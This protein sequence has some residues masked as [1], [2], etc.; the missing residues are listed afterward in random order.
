MGISGLP[1]RW[2]ATLATTVSLLGCSPS[3]E[4]N[5][6]GKTLKIAFFRDNTTLVSLDPFQVYWLEHRV[7]LRNVAES[8]TDQD[9]Q[10][11]KII[12]WLATGWDISDNALEYT[13]HLRKDVT[14]SNG[15][16]F[17]ARAVKTA[18]DADKAFAAQLPATF[19]ATYLAGY[20]HAEVVDDFT[21]KL[22]LTRPNAGF[23]Q[24]TSTT[25]LAILA[26]ESYAKS[27]KER[28]LGAIIGTGPFV[29]DHY[30]PESGLSLVKR[31]GY[32]WPSA[33]TLNRGEAH[34]DKVDVSYIPEESV[35]NGQFI[36]GQ[37]DILWPRNPFSEIDTQL[38]QSRNA[39]IQSRSLPGPALNWYPNTRSERILSDS[40]VRQALQKAIDRK[41]Y[42]S[43]VYNQQF[44]VVSGLYDTTTPYYKNQSDK[45]AFDPAGAGKVL[46]DAGWVL[47][48]DGYRTKNGKRL[49][50]TYN[51]QIAE[52]AGDVLIQ[53]QLRQIGID[54]KLNVLTV[55]DWSAANAAGNYDLTSTYMTRADPIILQTIIDPRTANS[56]T[57]AT[58][59]YTPQALPK[60]ETLF[61]AGMT[62]TTGE[63]RAQAYGALQDLLLDEGSVFPIYERVWQAATSP[64]VSNFRWTA[65]GFALLSDIELKQP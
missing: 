41:T 15:T 28:S 59:L 49:K 34:L 7:V 21:V 29:L 4:Q 40:A 18:F 44:P 27:A 25:N 19:G 65:E 23:L 22:L 50:L 54:L 64:R 53:D 9:P 8:L 55:A 31:A 2:L 10:T 1:I 56:A 63:Q 3:A 61:D 47:G 26:P 11:G 6:H 36:Q 20:D 32:A 46:D 16:R 33:N 45:L 48:A 14:F 42:A 57:V 58:N 5:T 62:A 37:V 17:D 51:V 43:T 35:R 38:F 60:A 30:T 24:A 12:P 52:G 13:F 39:T